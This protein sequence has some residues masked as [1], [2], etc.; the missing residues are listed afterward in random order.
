[1][2][3]RILSLVLTCALLLGCISGLTLITS[4]ETVVKVF[5]GVPGWNNMDDEWRGTYAGFDVIQWKG[6]GGAISFNNGSVANAMGLTGGTEVDLEIKVDYYWDKVE[7]G[8]GAWLHFRTTNIDGS[9]TP[10]DGFGNFTTYG[11]EPGGW[12]ELTVTRESQTLGMGGKDDLYINVDGGQLGAAN[13]LYIRGLSFKA[14][15]GEGNVYYANWGSYLTASIDFKSGTPVLKN[16]KNLASRGGDD[17]YV[18]EQIGETGIYGA[19]IFNQNNGMKFFTDNMPAF[20]E[21]MA[22]SVEYYMDSAVVDNNTRINFRIEGATR[23]SYVL[24]KQMFTGADVVN[25]KEDLVTDKTGLYTF[26]ISDENTLQALAGELGFIW[27]SGKTGDYAHILSISITPASQLKAVADPGYEYYDFVKTYAENP[28]YPT[29]QKVDSMGMGYSLNN[30]EG[31]GTITANGMEMTSGTLYFTTTK[32]LNKSNVGVKIYLAEEATEGIALQYQTSDENDTSYEHNFKEA[33][34]SYDGKV[35]ST[36]LTDAA[37]TNKQQGNYSFRFYADGKTIERVEVYVLADKTALNEAIAKEID[38]TG[39][40]A[41]SIAAYNAVKDAAQA[42]ADNV[43]ATE[44]EIADAIAKLAAAE[45]ALKNIREVTFGD[46]LGHIEFD[47]FEGEYKD[48]GAN[49]GFTDQGEWFEYEINVKEEALYNINIEMATGNADSTIEVQDGNGKVYGSFVVPQA[50]WGTYNTYTVTAP[51]AAGVQ[52]LRIVYKQSSANYRGLTL[53]DARYTLTNATWNDRH[54]AAGIVKKD[55]KYAIYAAHNQGIAIGDSAGVLNGYSKITLELTYWV[56]SNDTYTGT[57]GE[58]GI[59]HPNNRRVLPSYSKAGNTGDGAVIGTYNMFNLAELGGAFD[60]WT[61][62]SWTVEDADFENVSF[63]ANQDIRF[64]YYDE[65]ANA[66]EFKGGMYISKVKAYA[67]EDPTKY[68]EISFTETAN[69]SALKAEVNAAIADLSGYTSST[70]AAYTAALEAAQAILADENVEQAAIDAALANLVAAKE[71]LT[72]VYTLN[73]VTGF[74]NWCAG[75][76]E[77]YD[78]SYAWL[79]DTTGNN[80]GLSLNGYTGILNDSATIVY[81]VV[82]QF[83][84]NSGN[85]QVVS[86][87]TKEDNT[88]DHIWLT[89]PASEEAASDWYTFTF[90]VENANKD[91]FYAST[92]LT[93]FGHPG[94]QATKIYIRS[95]KAYDAEDPTKEVSIVF[96]TYPSKGDLEDALE[97]AVNTDSYTAASVEAYNAALAAIEELLAKDEVTEDEVVAA[98]AA[99]KAAEA[100]LVPAYSN[101][102]FENDEIHN[103]NSNIT[104]NH[105]DEDDEG[106]GIFEIYENAGIYGIK[107]SRQNRG[108]GYAVQ[109]AANWLTEGEPV[110]ITVTYYAPS[111][112]IQDNSRMGFLFEGDSWYRIRFGANDGFA[113]SGLVADEVS[114][115]TITLSEADAAKVLANGSFNIYFWN[116]ND[117]D[118]TGGDYIYLTEIRVHNPLPAN[119]EDLQ[120]AVDAA[121]QDLSS[122]TAASAEAYAAAV[123][124]AKAVLANEEATA[125]DIKKA[126]DDLT[127][128]AAALEKQAY[129]VI[130]VDIST[131]QGDNPKVGDKVFFTFT[132]KNNGDVTIPEGAKYG[133]IVKIGDTMIGWSDNYKSKDKAPALAPGET[134]VLTLCGG[135]DGSDGSWTVTAEAVEVFAQVNDN[136]GDGIFE[137][138][139]TNNT[140]TKTIT[141]TTLDFAALN[142]A[143]EDE[144]KDLTGYTEDSAAA[145]TA[146]LEAAKAL[147]GKLDATQEEIDAAVKALTDAKAALKEIPAAIM[148]DVDGDGE[149]TS[150]DARLV[151]QLYA[152]KITE[153]DLD[154]NVADVDGDKEITSTDARLIL[155][156]YAKKIDAF[157][158]PAE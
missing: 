27:W 49:I 97:N 79:F 4:A 71:A 126:M 74:H 132:V 77:K 46:K 133:G 13:A 85:F 84:S 104:H 15:D 93:M 57:V 129:D 25:E 128:A 66:A 40:T 147:A 73:N 67:T 8:D 146:A 26:I 48:E 51:L 70:A 65:G 58:G 82:A 80:K 125:A 90:T 101:M 118:Q 52:K 145:Y 10:D 76:I 152:K 116:H 50:D 21:P 1:M 34:L 16:M 64:L 150:T 3:K 6:R 94:D 53:T 137:S 139:T 78:G 12:K 39:K 28:Y 148:G 2:A 83:E 30:G 62:V 103:V 107:L 96:A 144:V 37:F 75:T 86:G 14:T 157:P 61:T 122:Y 114:S 11:M 59:D 56:E 127:A 35:A 158:T 120:A 55:G 108:F 121:I 5:N 130:V 60:Q 24:R 41:A 100:T 99:L 123:E 142:A 117:N 110:Q 109:N 156:L 113:A 36:V 91:K 149:I 88:V 42:V 138:D 22:I 45:A 19:K 153:A 155:Q 7:G 140:F 92:P 47:H 18:V 63:W 54:W 32:A 17:Q 131:T 89:A 106:N 68:I 81:E 20:T 119:K 95:F 31:K 98:L 124:A 112:V 43:W 151:L 141:P 33:T 87:Y 154:V 44:G 72:P 69:K 23:K 38:F 9:Y 134:L 111:A 105:P 102:T 143:I 29:Y 135:P 136:P 115:F